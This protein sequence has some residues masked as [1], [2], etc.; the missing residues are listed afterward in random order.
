MYSHG[1]VEVF[2]QPLNLAVAYQILNNIRSGQMRSCLAM[3]LEEKDLKTL[4]DPNCMGA[5]VN[6]SVPW[7]RVVVDGTVVHRLLEHVR[8]SEEEELIRRSVTLGGSSLM[9]HE[10]FGLPAKEVAV[11]REVLGVPN[12]KGRVPNVSERDEALLWQYWIKLT[13]S[14][15]TDFGDMRSVLDVAILMTE[16]VPALSLAMIWKVIQSWIAQDLV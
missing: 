5:L 14:H 7:F 16:C 8:T 6:S 10:I 9:I 2:V 1:M 13:K 11:R 4:I 15:G 12:R 3:G